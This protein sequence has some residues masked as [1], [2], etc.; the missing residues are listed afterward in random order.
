MKPLFIM[1]CRLQQMVNNYD[2]LTPWNDKIT[3]LRIT[4]G[5][6]AMWTWNSSDDIPLHVKND[7]EWLAKQYVPTNNEIKQ[8]CDFANSK[9]C[10]LI[11][12]HN[13]NDSVTNTLLLKQRFIQAGGIIEFDEIGNELYLNKFIKVGA[14]SKNTP[15]FIK[16]ITANNYKT[17]YTTFVSAIRSQYPNIKIIGIVAPDNTASKINWNNNV[18]IWYSSLTDDLT[19]DYLAIHIYSTTSANDDDAFGLPLSSLDKWQ[20]PLAVTEAGTHSADHSYQ[21]TQNWLS[22][23][24]ELFKYLRDRNDGSIGGT[25]VLYQPNS[26]AENQYSLHYSLTGITPIGTAAIENSWEK[27]NIIVI[28]PE[29]VVIPEPVIV[30]PTCVYLTE[31]VGYGK[32]FGMRTQTLKWSDNSITNFNLFFKREVKAEEIGVLCKLDYI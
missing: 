13:V 5:S 22:F 10:K 8:F 31:I 32:M 21:G 6:V 11:F 7:A 18:G 28:E 9:N 29:P 4:G 19:P 27:E 25:H 2:K 17:L 1:N 12:V 30:T 14:G 15:G 24:T 3:H 23:H 26:R 16:V 20:F